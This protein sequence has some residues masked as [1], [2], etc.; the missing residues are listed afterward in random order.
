[1]RVRFTT[2]AQRDLTQISTFLR[3]HH[4]ETA[5]R[6]V[7]TLIERAKGLV[8]QPYEGRRADEANVRVLIVSQLSYLIFYSVVE[9]E[10]HIIHIRHS[11][12]NR[13]E[14]WSEG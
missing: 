13:P 14:F 9:D 8:E 12:R 11:S 10:I 4:P 7:S 6:L 1:M 5:S 3:Q 2:P